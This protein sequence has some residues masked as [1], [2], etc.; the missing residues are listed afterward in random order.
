M[1]TVSSWLPAF[2]CTT[3]A[4][5]SPPSD[6]RGEQPIKVN[7]VLVREENAPA[8]G[9]RLEWMLLTTEP[10]ATFAEATV[11][12]DHYEKRWLIEEFHKAWKSGCRVE[13]R[14]LQSLDALERMTAITAHV[15]VRIL[16]LRTV[17]TASA[18]TSCEA[19][20]EPDE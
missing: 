5:L 16:Q 2:P 17:A 20:L 15:A 11:V 19:V 13:T 1:S 12:V 4:P 9:T 7:A 6:R 18:E 3:T 10:V 8:G 14:P